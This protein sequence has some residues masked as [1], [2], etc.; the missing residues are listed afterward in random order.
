MIE[1]NLEK[2]KSSIAKFSVIQSS[3]E[4][5]AEYYDLYFTQINR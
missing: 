1:N 2:I 4:M 3:S 5:R